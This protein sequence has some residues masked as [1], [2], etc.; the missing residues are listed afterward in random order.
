MCTW[1]QQKVL[2]PIEASREYIRHA[3]KTFDKQHYCN[4][5][6][7]QQKKNSTKLLFF[8]AILASKEVLWSLTFRGI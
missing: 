5:R 3:Y 1:S 6:Y 4:T 2:M 7:R 8:T